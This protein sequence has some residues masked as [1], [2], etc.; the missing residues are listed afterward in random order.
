MYQPD[1][2]NGHTMFFDQIIFADTYAEAAAAPLPANT[3]PVA[4]P[5]NAT[6]RRN[7]YAD[8]DLATLAH[9]LETPATQCLY[10]VSATNGTAT[11]LADGHT[12]RF[13]PT[14][15]FVGTAGYAYTVTDNG[16]D[17]RELLHYS[18]EPPDTGANGFVTDNSGHFRD[19][20]LVAVGTG[21][22]GYSTNT[23]LPI[24]DSASLQ[25]TKSGATNAARLS[26]YVTEPAEFNFSDVSWTFS[27]WFQRASTSNHDFIFYIGTGDGFGGDGD[28]LQFYCPNG[29]SSL[30][31][32]HYNASNVLD[33]NLSSAAIVAAG[34]WHHAALVF[35]R[36]NTNAGILRAYL[37]GAQFAATNVAW[38]LPQQ[39]PIVF[40]G[41][42]KTNSNLNRWFGGWLDDLVIFTNVLSASEISDLA[43]RTVRQF[44]G[45]SATN[46][47]S[48]IVTNYAPPELSEPELTNGNWSLSV[49]G[50]VG[51]S[52]VIQAST[53]LADWV[54]L[55]TTNPPGLPFYFA[56][57]WS[58]GIGP[59]FYRVVIGP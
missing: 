9:D 33:L 57:P 10:R 42:N 50:D 15:D 28:E 52:Y 21:T 48:V 23:P 18:F 43:T 56:E 49:N 1:A 8:V 11:L 12:A 27:G 59:R 53:N 46:T 38:A 51:P 36:T 39:M 19:G 20:N 55:L 16:E 2:N 4:N 34:Q 40:G 45:L 17:P 26:R 14:P 35:E 37:D 30:A 13:T 22:F 58:N 32:Q 25:L 54:T 7:T 24:Y 5:G 31:L 29:G 3:P 47:V 41:H 44:G 6:I